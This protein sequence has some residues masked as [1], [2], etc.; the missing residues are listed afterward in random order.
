[1]ATPVERTANI[2]FDSS[3]KTFRLYTSKSIYAFSVSPE[4]VLEHLHWGE[5]LPEGYDLRY[6]CQSSRNT[7][8]TVTEVAPDRFGGKI[9]LEAETL[10]EIQSTWRENR[11]WAP[12]DMDELEQFQHRRLE[13]YSWRIMSKISIHD[14]Q[15]QNKL[16]SMSRRGSLRSLASTSDLHSFDRKPQLGTIHEG[17]QLDKCDIGPMDTLRSNLRKTLKTAPSEANLTLLKEKSNQQKSE[18]AS[19]NYKHPILDNFK[20]GQPKHKRSQTFNRTIGKVGKGGLCVEF[21]D[22]GT[23]DFRT[24]SF[25]IVDNY[26]GSSIS[27]LR[28]RRH[29]IYK[30][31]LSMPDGMPGI[32]CESEDDASTL[33]VTLA[34]VITGIEV[35]IIYGKISSLAFHCLA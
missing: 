31:K 25:L 22:H 7:H 26:N 34:D 15:K 19:I 3:D 29:R 13:N 8:F 27:P 9:V 6:L 30:G 24:P 33:V 16:S 18:Q 5:R 20:S 32:K 10:E 21:A 28:Y 35:D 4:L 17:A 23:G 11:V 2:S 12:K 14:S 1:M